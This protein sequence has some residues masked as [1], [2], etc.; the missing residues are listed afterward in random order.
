MSLVLGVNPSD[1]NV[2]SPGEIFGLALMGVLIGVLPLWFFPSYRQ[3]VLSIPTSFVTGG[4]YIAPFA[5]QRLVA[6]YS[7]NCLNL[8]LLIP[9]FVV[10]IL[11]V[12]LIY[13]LDQLRSG[14]YPVW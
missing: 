4:Q 6:G 11:A 14:W 5:A 7:V 8:V 2:L 9:A 3:V 12:V 13:T 10:P 1:R